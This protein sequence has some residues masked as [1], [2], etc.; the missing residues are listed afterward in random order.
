MGSS[1][2]WWSA[3]ITSLISVLG[4]LV[5]QWMAN[6]RERR[7]N[8]FERHQQTEERR[9]TIY[10]DYIRAANRLRRIR[11]WSESGDRVS[12]V[13]EFHA[14]VGSV[15]LVA[16]EPVRECAELSG[17]AAERLARVAPGNPRESA[18]VDEAMK[19][20]EHA[21]EATKK[22]MRAELGTTVSQHR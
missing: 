20:L 10:A 7:R 2:P 8:H 9:S 22:A 15:E 4:V 1:A 19:D 17:R 21:V 6:R 12:I 3:A 5:T 13:D 18:V 11:D 16:D 14:S